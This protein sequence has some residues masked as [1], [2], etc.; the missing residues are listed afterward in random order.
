MTQAAGHAAERDRFFEASLDRA[1]PEIYSAVADELGR[2]KKQIEL[3]ASENIVS[4]RGAAGAGLGAHQQIRRGLS[5][6][7]LLW[8]LRIRR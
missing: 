4:K 2:Q 8:R 5:G 7:A 3:I 1:D 6:P